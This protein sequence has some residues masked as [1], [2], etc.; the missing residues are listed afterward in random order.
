AD[1]IAVRTDGVH[2]AP[3]YDPVGTLVYATQARDVEH[4]YV[5]GRPLVR[6]G[7]LLTLDAEA[8]VAA[9]QRQGKRLM[10]RAKL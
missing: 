8:I 3:A 1:L 9:A 5:D 6:N 2:V 10:S 7:E 4:V